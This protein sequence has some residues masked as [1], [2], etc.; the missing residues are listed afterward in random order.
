MKSSTA[1]VKISYI[2]CMLSTFTK[3]TIVQASS[4]VPILLKSIEKA[5]SQPN[6]PVSIAE[7]ICVAIFLLKLLNVEKEKEQTFQ[8]M[9]NALFDMNKQLFVSENFLNSCEEESKFNCYFNS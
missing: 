8:V 1:S 3:K 6:V 7:G 2:Q 5:V 9:W 4:L